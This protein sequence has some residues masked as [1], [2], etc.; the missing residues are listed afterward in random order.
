MTC[1]APACP[2]VGL[3]PFTEEQSEFFFGRDKERRIITANLRTSR[4]TLLY[5]ESGVG[6]SSVLQA[7]VAKHLRDEA[8][9]NREEFGEPEFA[10]VYFADWRDD[11]IVDLKRAVEAA[12]RRTLGDRDIEPV[13]ALRSLVDLLE[14][15]SERVD[16]DLLIIFDQFEEYFLYHPDESGDGTFATEFARAVNR[17][18]LRVNF[19]VSMREDALAKL[20]RFKGYIPGLFDNFL[21]ID[22]LDRE[23]AR[24]AIQGPIDKYNELHTA[25][26]QSVSV[27]PALVDA[28]LDQVRSGE[29]EIGAVGRGTVQNV[30]AKETRVETPYLQ[31][32]MTRLWEAE[33]RRGDTVLRLRT[34]ERLD[35]AKQIVKTHV[36]RAIEA[37]AAE[38]LNIVGHIFDRLV[39]PSGTK[40]A[41]TAAD[42]A[43]FARV[44]T[45]KLQPILDELTG[46]KARI[47]RPVAP[48]LDQ[49]DTP[50]YEIFHDVLGSAVLDWSGRHAAERKL[51]RT[52]LILF[53]AAVVVAVVV[54]FAVKALEEERKAIKAAKAA[55]AQTIIAQKNEARS[56]ILQGMTEIEDYNYARGVSYF[57]AAYSAAQTQ[58]HEPFHSSARNLIA[59]W[60]QHLGMPLKHTGEV[61]A[62]AFSPGG[63]RIVT[64]SENAVHVWN[65]ATGELLWNAGTGPPEKL[66]PLS[67]T[68]PVVG[69]AFSPNG[70]IVLAVV[71]DSRGIPCSLLLWNAATGKRCAKRMQHSGPV[72][73]VE[74]SPD[75]KMILTGSAHGAHMWDART[76]EARFSMK[77]AALVTTVAFSPDGKKLLTG[78]QTLEKNEAVLWNAFTGMQL[79]DRMDHRTA[80]VA[81]AFS[82]N[83]ERALTWPVENSAQLWDSTTGES[84]GTMMQHE[85]TVS[86]VA[87]S[88]DRRTALVRTDDGSVHLWDLTTGE[89]CGT[90]VEYK[91]SAAALSSDGSTIIAVGDHN[92]VSLW[93]AASGAAIGKTHGTPVGC[94][95]FPGS[96]GLFGAAALSPE[97]KAV[98]L[99]RDNTVARVWEAGPSKE[100]AHKTQ[101]NALD[102]G[103]DGKVVLARCGI[104]GAQLWDMAT[105]KPLGNLVRH[106]KR[107]EDSIIAAAFGPDGKTVLTGGYGTAALLYNVATAELACKP[108]P[109]D[110]EVAAVAIS[111]DG[112]TA[113]TG[114]DDT[115]RLWNI[116]TGKQLTPLLEHDDAVATVAFS[117]DGQT[118]LTGTLRKARLWNAQN[119]TLIHVMEPEAAL[120]ATA[121]SPDGRTILTVS[122]GWFPSEALLW[123]ASSGKPVGIPMKH[124]G[125]LLATAGFS[126]D[127]ATVLTVSYPNGD[128]P[129]ELGLWDA[130]TGEPRGEIIRHRGPWSNVAFSPDGK[131]IVTAGTDRAARLWD[132][133]TGKPRGELLLNG[134]SVLAVAFSPDGNTVLT[135][136]NDNR[137][138]LWDVSLPALDKSDRLKRSVEVRTGLFF[139]KHGR[140][141]PLTREQWLDKKKKLKALGGPCD[142]VR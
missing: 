15:W 106:K 8:A 49:L 101:V 124:D 83:G 137:V 80:I 74:F 81:V 79:G 31:L 29:T 135:S 59:G 115:A 75:S 39:T 25:E 130:R 17:A 20:D 11:P 90:G 140:L 13:P 116:T 73:A 45:D 37:L 129:T 92:S 132:V 94:R 85:R 2:Y 21:R 141:Q 69:V 65:A 64:G 84:L 78:T 71:E 119:G 125:R 86:N 95:G 30:Q 128:Q 68:S 113:L 43:K 47:L 35:G 60:S 72:Y 88:S 91:T 114:S 100:L 111:P 28:V 120:L 9:Q 104:W 4:L 118:V 108:L 67:M 66:G 133:G 7:G 27:E 99:G 19:L 87:V 63:K 102:I 107:A 52:Q 109:H 33:P 138:R 51:Q 122:G 131:S 42:L 70:K 142:I 58:T 110:A 5:G 89:R 14:A 103:P 126:P 136:S 96:T 44:S 97:G 16:G 82:P 57:F 12:V 139:D 123:N 10:V 23:S 112:T 54:G 55:E 56:Y 121:F 1:E 117:P 41:H 50:R 61:L 3:T 24:A 46:P 40:I 134:G 98:I 53:A 38:Q 62:A 26:G 105:G 93:S 77:H 32:V 6:K 76:G 22:H 34:L 48:P 127:G 36:D 18:D